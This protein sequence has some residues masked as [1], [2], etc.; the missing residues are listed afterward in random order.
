M[1]VKMTPEDREG[2]CVLTCEGPLSIGTGTD[3]FNSAFG[4]WIGKG[5]GIVLDLSRVTYMDST[6]LAS[7]V[8]ASRKAEERGQAMKLVLAPDGATRNAFSITQLDRILDVFGD[9]ESALASLR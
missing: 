8:A 1:A 2:I 7:V 9:V 4:E 6:G 5:R 3:G